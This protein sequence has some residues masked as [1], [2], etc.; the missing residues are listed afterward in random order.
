MG[1]SLSSIPSGASVFVDA[2]IFLYVF[3]RHP[4]YGKDSHAF[5]KRIEENDILGFADEFV[6]NEVFHKLMVTSVVEQCRC[7]PI[8]AVAVI[9]KLLKY[10]TCARRYGKPV[11]CWKILL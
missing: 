8:Q 1:L 7:S 5:I 3:F 4:A 10:L 11:I 2:N 9:K 6:L